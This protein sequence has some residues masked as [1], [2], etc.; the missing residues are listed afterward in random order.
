MDPLVRKSVTGHGLADYAGQIAG[1]IL[2][3]SVG[4]GGEE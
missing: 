3:V 1:K 2:P 4:E